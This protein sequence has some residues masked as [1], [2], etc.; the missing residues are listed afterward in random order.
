MKPLIIIPAR[1][2][3]KGIPHKN[4]KALAGRPLIAYT[5]ATAMAAAEKLGGTVVLSTDD[6]E[7]AGVARREGLTVDYMRPTTLGGDHIGSREVMLDVM[8]WADSRG[9]LYD[10][11][12]LLQPTSPLRTA[13]DILG[14][15]ALYTSDIDMA[16]SVCESAANP[17][18][19]LFETDAEGFLHISKGDGLFKRR[20]DVP[21]VLEYNG[22]VYVINPDSLR[23][24][25]LGEFPRRLP[26]EMPRSRS[27][28]LDTPDDW[29]VAEMIVAR[30]KDNDHE[31]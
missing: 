14:T 2:G 9:T 12:I 28:D 25:E 7:I 27:L 23:R 18:Y 24:M 16:V 29:L 8:A 13:G 6:D 1:G 3:S 22:A 20:Q 30:M 17:Y 19:T 26:Y 11:V 4:V 15:T 21:K 31:L 5:I 10:C